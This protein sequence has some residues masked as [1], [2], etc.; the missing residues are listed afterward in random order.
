MA[1]QGII[2]GAGDLGLRVAGLR[3]GL[4]DAVWA[5]RR[6]NL[7]VPEGIQA[8]AGDLHSPA[9]LA[10]LPANADWMVFCATPDSRNARAYQRLYVDGFRQARDLLKPKRCLFVSSTAVYAQNHGEWVNESSDA[11]ADTFNGRALR[12]A[13]RI[14]LQEPSGRVLRL[15]GITGP[16]RNMLINKALLGLECANVWSNRIHIADAAAA[17][18][19]VLELTARQP[20]WIAND[21]TP[22]LQC[23]VVNWIRQCH[24]LPPLPAPE[25]LAQGRRVSNAQLKASGWQPRFAS[26]RESYALSAPEN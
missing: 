17:V 13:E 5:L 26:Y 8:L 23:E 9:D 11:A 19:H 22:A 21:D 20:L 15:S 16:G 12:E 14:C 24:N 1:G 10:L 2:I 7:P 25:G 4:G 3:A 6:R 18:S